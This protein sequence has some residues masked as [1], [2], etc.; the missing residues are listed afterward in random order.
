MEKNIVKWASYGF[1]ISFGLAIL[2]I[3]YKIKTPFDGG[4]TIEYVNVY[5]YVVSI[6]R[7]NVIGGF[8]GAVVGWRLTKRDKKS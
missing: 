3:D 4:H 5:D 8:L 7:Y 6:L 1:V 2:F